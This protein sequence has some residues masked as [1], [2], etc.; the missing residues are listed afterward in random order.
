M[1]VIAIVNE[2]GGVAKTTTAV[3]VACG[4]AARRRRVVLIDT[5]EQGHVCRALGLAK[6]PGFFE[7]MQRNKPWKDVLVPIPP[8]KFLAPGRARMSGGH[9]LI[10]PSDVETRAMQ[11]DGFK[12]T[13]SGEGSDELWASYGFAYHALQKQDWHTYRRDLFLTQARKNFPRSNKIF[14]AH[15]IECRLPFLNPGVVEYALSLPQAVVQDGRTHPKAVLQQAFLG[16]LP[17]YITRRPKVAFQDGMGIKD[18]IARQFA[19]PKRFYA[20]EYARRYG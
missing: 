6:A 19:D 4:L 9:L 2:K 12:V 10:V 7:L 13:F 3:T 11:A 20:A 15:S 18:A 17:D 5:D 1:K 14:M 16:K 8:E